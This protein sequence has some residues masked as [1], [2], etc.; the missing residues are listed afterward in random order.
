M[1]TFLVAGAPADCSSAADR[2]LACSDDADA[3]T[4]SAQQELYEH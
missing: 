1:L 3:S 2:L 4:A